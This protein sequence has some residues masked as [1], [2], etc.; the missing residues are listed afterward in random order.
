MAFALCYIVAFVGERRAGRGEQRPRVA[1]SF[2]PKRGA[3][4]SPALTRRSV[5]KTPSPDA[6]VVTPAR[7]VRPH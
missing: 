1:Y 5:S 3:W 4:P 2:K 6:A 7:R